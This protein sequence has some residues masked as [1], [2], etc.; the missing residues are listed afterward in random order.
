VT[1]ALRIS[2]ASFAVALVP[3]ATGVAQATEGITTTALNSLTPACWGEMREADTTVAFFPGVRFV[4]GYC[5]GEHGDPRSGAVAADDDGVL[6]LLS[7]TSSFN[8]LVRRHA[9]AGLDS[10]SVLTYARLALE[11]TGHANGHARVLV[12]WRGVPDTARRPLNVGQDRPLFVSSHSPRGGW[13][14]YFATV[15]PGYDRSYFSRN[16]VSVERD[17]RVFVVDDS[18]VYPALPTH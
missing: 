3:A 14:V 12:S 9:P 2:W 15:E 6:Y 4:R 13:E 10:T 7:S 16:H 11:F 1:S 17:G 5:L 8:F 18:L